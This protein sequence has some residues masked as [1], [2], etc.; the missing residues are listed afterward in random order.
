VALVLSSFGIKD[1]N[2]NVAKFRGRLQDT[3][4][5]TGNQIIFE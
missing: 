3:R 5:L 1:W 2:R 4:D